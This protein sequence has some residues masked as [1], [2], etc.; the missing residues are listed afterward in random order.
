M[1]NNTEKESNGFDSAEETVLPE[2]ARRQIENYVAIKEQEREIKEATHKENMKDLSYRRW[3]Y[4]NEI[5]THMDRIPREYYY[6]AEYQDMETLA[7]KYIKKMDTLEKDEDFQALVKEFRR[8][9]GKKLDSNKVIT[10][11]LILFFAAFIGFII[12]LFNA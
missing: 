12:Y 6:S 10:I 5:Q 1:E 8:K 9:T 7:E 2:Q 4:Q 11:F 3:Y